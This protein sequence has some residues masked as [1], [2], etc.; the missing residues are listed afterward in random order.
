M[1]ATNNTDALKDRVIN[2]AATLYE[3]L[4]IAP[5]DRYQSSSDDAVWELRDA[6]DALFD[7]TGTPTSWIR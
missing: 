2:A 6:I 3:Y 1:S 4:E 5:N 7:Q